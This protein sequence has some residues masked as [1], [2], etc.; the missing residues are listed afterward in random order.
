ML[1]VIT[2]FWKPL[3]KTQAV[4]KLQPGQL[5]IGSEIGFGFV[6]QT[7]LSGRR[8][9]ISAINTYQFGDEALTS[10]VLS[11]AGEPD[12]SMIVAEAEG[13]QYLA[14]SRRIPM[15][16]RMKLFDT[17]DLE[18]I[19]DKPDASR[20]MTKEIIP[21]F[22][23][24][25]VMSY[26][27]EI[28]GL[29][30]RLFKG[31]SRKQALPSA[32]E[33]QEF[34]YTLLVS[35]SNEHAIEIEK[36]RDGMV[37]VYATIY[38]RLNDIGEV[39]H[40][41]MDA[42]LGDIKMPSITEVKPLT[43]AIEMTAANDTAKQDVNVET[44]APVIEAPKLVSDQPKPVVEFKAPAAPLS[45]AE[46]AKKE[47]APQVINDLK[48]IKTLFNPPAHQPVEAKV[49]APVA[50]ESKPE[51][52]PAVAAPVSI[53]TP[54]NVIQKE[55]TPMAIENINGSNSDQDRN[56]LYVQSN[57]PENYNK[58]EIKAVTKPMTNFEGDSIEC[59][60]RV[61]NKIIDEAIRNEMRLTDIVRRIIEL[62]VAYPESVQIPV[63]LTDEDYALLGIRYGVTASDR[64]TIKRRIIEDLNDFSGNKKKAA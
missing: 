47:D 4:E 41:E 23:A 5:Q 6:P 44:P 12:V 17:R 57:S 25:T 35:D 51:I 49:E 48:Q 19:L 16:D 18:N 39:S 36:S 40:P 8:V 38:R 46:P 26:K 60:L 61:A 53:Q 34:E 3:K 37:E 14:I 52:K 30:G 59:D 42:S 31:D 20:L 43:S 21:D 56:R 15:N 28:Q 45:I 10:F 24:W 27:R 55:T 11:Q 2:D 62:P 50:P 63:T 9:R 29:K 64:N 33:A 58:Q 7:I 32:A 1:D 13:E 54:T 22:K